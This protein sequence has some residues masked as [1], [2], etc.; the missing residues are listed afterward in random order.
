M[1]RRTVGSIAT[2]LSQQASHSIDPREIQEATEKEY[3]RELRWCVEHA[4]KKEPC[5]ENCPKECADREKLDGDFFIECILKKEKL[6]EN[7]LRNYFIPRTTCP[8]PFYD[9][10]VYKF[11]AASQQIEFIWVVPDKDTCETFKENKL[12]IVPAERELLQNVLNFYDGTLYRM[13][14]KFNNENM[15]PG[16]ALK[17][18]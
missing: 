8:E 12:H 4:Q 11:N 16:C 17:E 3:L 5:R 14:K 9:R 10:T 13:M 6:L 7:V 1:S 18:K 2:E 15:A